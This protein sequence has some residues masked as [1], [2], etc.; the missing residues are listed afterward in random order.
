MSLSHFTFNG[1][2]SGEFGLLV[3]NVSAFGAPARVVEKVQIPYHNGDLLIDTGAYQN[4]IVTYEVAIIQNT[5]V[6]MRNIADWLLNTNGYCE[7]SDDYTPDYYRLGAYYNQIDYTMTMLNRYGSATISFDCKPQR[8]LNSGKT[9]QVFTEGGTIVNPTN[10]ASKPI[11]VVT[12]NGSFT[13]NGE[14]VTVTHNPWLD[15]AID[16]ERMVCYTL[17][18]NTNMANNVTMNQFP[19]L[20]TGTNELSFSGFSKVTIYPR[21]WRL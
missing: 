2:S 10:M 16:S 1:K 11:I 18:D 21:W 8:Y 9:P 5:E 3:S 14:E 7:L 20:K 17:R 15:T 6:N 12:S 19:V 4:Y 13:L